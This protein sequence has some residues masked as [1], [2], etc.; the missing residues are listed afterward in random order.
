MLDNLQ[1]SLRDSIRESSF[2]RQL[3]V[4][5]LTGV[6]V[7]P[8]MLAFSEHLHPLRSRSTAKGTFADTA[9]VRDL[10]HQVQEGLLEI[11]EYEDWVINRLAVSQVYQPTSIRFGMHQM[12]TLPLV[13]FLQMKERH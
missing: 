4:N 7:M 9:R 3:S 8:Q 6:N 5:R 10:E 11:F 13:H 2:W 1:P 12:K